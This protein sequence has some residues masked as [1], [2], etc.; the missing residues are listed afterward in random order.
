MGDE[1]NKTKDPEYW[2]KLLKTSTDKKDALK[3]ELNVLRERL[4]TLENT[5]EEIHEETKE[6]KVNLEKEYTTL[7]E[8]FIDKV[9]KKLN[10][11]SKMKLNEKTPIFN[12]KTNEDI[13]AWFYTLE[14]NMKLNGIKNDI[15]KVDITGLYVREAALHAY[16]SVIDSGKGDTWMNF[17]NEFIKRFV[18]MR[19][20]E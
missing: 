8:T 5:K 16:K 1:E 15:D 10:V 11:N 19:N 14:H 12:G 7:I 18:K 4:S 2:A 9:D 13:H 3:R 6:K 20:N 17:K